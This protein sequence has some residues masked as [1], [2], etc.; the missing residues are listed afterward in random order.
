MSR[1]GVPAAPGACAPCVGQRTRAIDALEF[2][3]LSSPRWRSIQLTP[4]GS[5]MHGGRPP[6]GGAND[7]P[8]AQRALE[9]IGEVG[10]LPG[11]TAVLFRRAAEMAV[12]GGAPIDRP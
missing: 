1:S 5:R 6:G 12:S 10:S 2:Q 3:S 9:R 8:S 4:V 7:G 11:E